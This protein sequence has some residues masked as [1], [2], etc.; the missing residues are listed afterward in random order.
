M[1]RREAPIQNLLEYASHSLV[2]HVRE[3]QQIEVS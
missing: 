2:R 3:V 1:V